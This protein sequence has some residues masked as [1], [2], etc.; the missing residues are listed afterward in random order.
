[1]YRHT[2]MR[3]VFANTQR[4]HNLK[5]L[6]ETGPNSR[7]CQVLIRNF[8]VYNLPI[9]YIAFRYKRKLLSK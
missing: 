6:P 5:L 7:G 8:F 9:I 4:K 1:M 3:R 2:H